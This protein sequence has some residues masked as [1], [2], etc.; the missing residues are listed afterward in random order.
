[1]IGR[2]GLLFLAAV[3]LSSCGLFKK[4]NSW[5]AFDSS[6]SDNQKDLLQGDLQLVGSLNFA[7]VTYEDLD[8]IDLPDLSGN[9]LAGFLQARVKFIVGEGFDAS[10]QRNVVA[11]YYNYSPS[12]MNEFSSAFDR[13][14]T[15][16]TNTGSAVYLDGKQSN[17]L[18][19]IN[20]ADQN[21]I[22][23][24]PR[25]GII[26]IGEGLFSN[27]RVNS[28]S[29]DSLGRRLLRLG[30]LFHES[31][32][33]DGNGS[34]AGFPHTKCNSGDFAGYY[35]CESNT[36]GPYNVE[37]MILKHFY[38]ICYNCSES[39]LSALQ[40]SAADAASRLVYGARKRD[41]QPE[42]VR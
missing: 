2:W 20:I 26:K 24:S 10:S 29:P 13:V 9:S 19:S 34:N 41:S 22:V 30:T 40:I 5:V 6:V 16:M 3:S 1:M 27:S 28:I 37:A 31:R 17:T 7:N 15:V 12:L 18:Y 42:Y 23:A 36:N 35:A 4:N 25:V 14:V 8:R 11:N 21:L 32:H 39:E 38:E 33:S